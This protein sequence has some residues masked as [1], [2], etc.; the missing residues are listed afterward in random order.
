MQLF[1][2]II[3]SLRPE[4]IRNRNNLVLGQ[5]LSQSL[6]FLDINYEYIYV[7]SQSEFIKA[8]TL[9]INICIRFSST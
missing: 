4:D 9:N 3:E 8:I 6:N 2:Y 7:N 5:V 1:V